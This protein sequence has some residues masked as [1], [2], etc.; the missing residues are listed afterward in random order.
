MNRKAGPTVQIIELG[1]ARIR[2][3]VCAKRFSPA[4]GQSAPALDLGM[5]GRSE[6][7]GRAGRVLPQYGSAAQLGVHPL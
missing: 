4:L 1:C 2:A 6:R 3:K 5:W 7:S